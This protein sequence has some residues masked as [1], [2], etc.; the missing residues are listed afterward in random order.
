MRAFAA[1]STPRL[2]QGVFQILGET[3]LGAHNLNS[4]GAL[5]LLILLCPV[6]LLLAMLVAA[7]GGPVF[8]TH[9]RES[10]GM[11]LPSGARNSVLY[12]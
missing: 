4:I 8:F 12:Q 1:F 6:F 11:A 2:P 5:C 3:F 10:A 9:E 7:D